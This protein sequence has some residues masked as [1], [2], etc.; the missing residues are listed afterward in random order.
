ML[1]ESPSAGLREHAG[2]TTL[3]AAWE[4]ECRA[5]RVPIIHPCWSAGMPVLVEGAAEPVLSADVQLR[6]QP[7]TVGHPGRSFSSTARVRPCCS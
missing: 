2:V 5:V 7:L 1:I 6:D 4:A 3:R